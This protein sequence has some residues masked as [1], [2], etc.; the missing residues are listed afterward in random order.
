M[1]LNSMI[2]DSN[3]RFRRQPV[4]ICKRVKQPLKNL[5]TF[6]RFDDRV[7]PFYKPGNK[8]DLACW[9]VD[10]NNIIEC[11]DRNKDLIKSNPNLLSKIEKLNGT[12]GFQ[13]HFPANVSMMARPPRFVPND[14]HSKS[15]NAGYTRNVNG[16]IPY[17]Y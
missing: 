13:R 7:N 11:I 15:T 4:S 16:G 17:F 10:T 14:A 5:H 12:T 9:N 8:A 6:T 3:P 2:C 1:I